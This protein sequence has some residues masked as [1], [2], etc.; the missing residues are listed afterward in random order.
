M[1]RA[2]HSKKL[3]RTFLYYQIAINPNQTG[4]LTG[5]FKSVTYSRRIEQLIL[6]KD[7]VLDPN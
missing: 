4:K 6:I 5:Q 3:F 7:K 1:S 2:V